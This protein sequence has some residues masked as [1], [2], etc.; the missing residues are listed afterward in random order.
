MII[1]FSFIKIPVS[2]YPLR[3]KE[4]I[5]VASETVKNGPAHIQTPG[6]LSGTQSLET[7]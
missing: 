1:A 6:T 4:I 7:R 5:T 3:W 2:R